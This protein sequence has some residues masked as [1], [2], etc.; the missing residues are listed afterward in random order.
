M[1]TPRPQNHRDFNV[2]T[3]GWFTVLKS[4]PRTT[5]LR[6]PGG[7]RSIANPFKANAASTE[8]PEQLAARLHTIK[9]PLIGD[10]GML[11]RGLIRMA[12][13]LLTAC[14]FT[15]LILWWIIGARL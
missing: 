13:I 15:S 1:K 14:S 8:A 12:L 10:T 3:A 9:I 2:A 11:D 4:A 5:T 6:P 7:H